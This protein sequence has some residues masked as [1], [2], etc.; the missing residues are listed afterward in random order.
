[1]LRKWSR[2][3]LCFNRAHLLRKI[4]KSTFKQKSPHSHPFPNKS[5]KLLNHLTL[6][7]QIG[8]F[9]SQLEVWWQTQ[10]EENKDDSVEPV[11]PLESTPSSLHLGSSLSSLLAYF[12]LPTPLPCTLFSPATQRTRQSHHQYSQAHL[13]ADPTLRSPSSSAC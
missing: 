12:L 6:E 1:M 5:G 13:W 7:Q 2:R 10:L 8:R 4:N 3:F 9:C 11:T